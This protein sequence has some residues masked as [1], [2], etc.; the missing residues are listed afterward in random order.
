MK[1]VCA[2]DSFK[3]SLSSRR[4]ASLAEEEARKI[5]PECEV[6]GLG[7]ADGGEGTADAVFAACGGKSREAIVQDPLGR[8]IA[9]RYG[10]LPDGTALI[11]MAAASGLTLVSEGERYPLRATTFGTG[12]LILDALNQGANAIVLGLGGSATN[13]AGTGA[14]EAMG[15][16][17]RDSAG[18]SLR[19]NGEN[20]E[21]IAEIDVSGL[22]PRIAQARF[23]A[24]LDVDSPLVG[25]NGATMMFGRQK[26]ASDADLQRL[27]HGMRSYLDILRH[28][29]AGFD[30]MPGDG[31]AGGMGMAARIFLH[32]RRVRGAD[33]ILDSI[34][35]DHALR[36]ADIC[37]TGEGHADRQSVNG[38]LVSRI[39]K[40][41]RIAGVPCIAIVGGMDESASGLEDCGVNAIYPSVIDCCSREEAIRHAERNFRL[42]VDRVLA[43]LK[44]GLE[45]GCGETVSKQDVTYGGDNDE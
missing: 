12:Q 3:E 27:E 26:G 20:L 31:A 29:A 39:A 1:I 13:D 16:R 14:L 35:F 9:A 44:I 22:D 6:V 11:E 23:T 30:E 32:A 28:N 18:N 8:P 37:L 24:L 41:C 45:A 38:K 36:D 19:G 5:F 42:A 17:F 34:G 21:R 15:V 10:I 25:M 33:W 40:R 4:A 7:V 43:T 2:I